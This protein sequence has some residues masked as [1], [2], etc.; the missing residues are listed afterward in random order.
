MRGPRK[1]FNKHMQDIKAKYKR[2]EKN[3]IYYYATDNEYSGTFRGELLGDLLDQ[4]SKKE[5]AMVKYKI[6]LREKVAE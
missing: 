3:D 6:D 4:L 5:L 1:A 2:T